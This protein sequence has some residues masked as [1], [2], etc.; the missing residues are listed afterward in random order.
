[1]RLNFRRGT[2]IEHKKYVRYGEGSDGYFL[3]VGVF[4]KMAEEAGAIIKRENLPSLVDCEKFDRY[5][6]KL[7][8]EE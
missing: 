8:A 5:L 7:Y 3:T 2:K 1:M 4:Q 6:A